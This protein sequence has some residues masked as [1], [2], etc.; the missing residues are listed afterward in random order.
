MSAM[1]FIVSPVKPRV[2]FGAGAIFSDIPVGLVY[3]SVRPVSSSRANSLAIFVTPQKRP[4]G[5]KQFNA[6]DALGSG[7]AA[8]QERSKKCPGLKAKKSNTVHSLLYC[9]PLHISSNKPYDAGDSGSTAVQKTKLVR[10]IRRMHCL[11]FSAW[12]R[13]REKPFIPLKKNARKH[14]LFE[15]WCL[16]FAAQ[17]DRRCW[18]ATEIDP[19]GRSNAGSGLR[20]STP[21]LTG[22][23]SDPLMIGPRA[24]E[25]I[26]PALSGGPRSVRGP[27]RLV[28]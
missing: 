16:Q 21:G 19:F 14:S 17:R 20:G 6:S 23:L 1:A 28:A 25:K 22:P 2:A 8:L 18:E 11:H 24:S 7:R 27:H 10:G 4:S 26:L 13:S 5:G 15:R 12:S 3:F 9:F